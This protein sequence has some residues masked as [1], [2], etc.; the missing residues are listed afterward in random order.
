MD[1]D[2]VELYNE[3]YVTADEPHISIQ[4]ISEIYCLSYGAASSP[5]NVWP[6]PYER[7]VCKAGDTLPDEGIKDGEM[8]MINDGK[9][10]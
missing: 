6:A 2:T 3:A 7:G 9:D 4:E 8:R 10:Q 1:E 5:Y